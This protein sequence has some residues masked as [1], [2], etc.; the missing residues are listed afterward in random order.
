MFGTCCDRGRIIQR[1]P[2]KAFY[3]GSPHHRSEVCIFSTSLGHTSPTGI[4][5]HIYHRCECPANTHSRSFDSRYACTVLGH[6]RIKRGRLPQRDR[7]YGLEAMND[8]TRH[9][10][11]NAQAGLLHSHALQ[12][13][14]AHRVHLIQ[15]R[16]DLT[17][18]YQSAHVLYIAIRRNLVHLPNLFFQCHTGQQSF[19]F[20]LDGGITFSV[21]HSG[22]RC[23]GKQ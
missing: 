7:E 6:L 23:K 9:Q 15:N 19:Y 4:A 14:D 20:L 22:T 3:H 8:I 1:I 18:L 2:L 21:L 17:F 5:R 10:Q 11:G 13:I 12:G 16:P